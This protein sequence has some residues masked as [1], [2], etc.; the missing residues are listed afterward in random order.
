MAG[1]IT[2]ITTGLTFSANLALQMLQRVVGH[3]VSVAN[4][5]PFG[6]TVVWNVTQSPV[7]I[8]LVKIT[9][10][11][12]RND[13]EWDVFQ[14]VEPNKELT[15][16]LQQIAESSW[17]GLLGEMFGQ[18]PGAYVKLDEITFEEVK[19]SWHTDKYVPTFLMADSEEFARAKRFLK[20]ELQT[21]DCNATVTFRRLADGSSSSVDVPCK[22]TFRFRGNAKAEAK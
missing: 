3:E 12:P 21:F 8:H 1:I 4:L 9:S 5:D 2:I 13:L 22:G 19:K 14:T 17:H 15:L 6:R 16:Q 7:S 18:K 20:T 11:A 10:A